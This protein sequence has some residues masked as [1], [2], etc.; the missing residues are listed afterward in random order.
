MW[1]YTSVPLYV[2]VAKYSDKFTIFTLVITGKTVKYVAHCSGIRL[3]Y[4]GKITTISG[5]PVTWPCLKLG[6]FPNSVLDR[7]YN[8]DVLDPR[9]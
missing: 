7:Y 2:F 8:T 4:L 5:F 3:E 1:I 6:T 9:M